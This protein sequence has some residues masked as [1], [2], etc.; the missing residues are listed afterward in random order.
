ME[1]VITPSEWNDSLS[2]ATK[3]RIN[4]L[5]SK[6]ERAKL[7]VEDLIKERQLKLKS[8]KKPAPQYPYNATYKD[9]VDKNGRAVRI[10]YRH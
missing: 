9:T 7:T 3:R 5:I 6:S 4:R 2:P 1:K 10:E 8:K